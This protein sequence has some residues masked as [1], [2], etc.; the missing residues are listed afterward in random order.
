ML[1]LLNS[2]KCKL[3]NELLSLFLSPFCFSTFSSVSLLGSWAYHGV[4]ANCFGAS[5]FFA[6]SVALV[7]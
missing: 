4:S 3:I 2:V 1:H 5:F 6:I 7:L